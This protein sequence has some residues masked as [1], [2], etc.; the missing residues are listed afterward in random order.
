[1]PPPLV[2]GVKVSGG[3][4]GGPSHGLTYGHSC[5]RLPPQG[6]RPRSVPPLHRS[7]DPPAPSLA[8]HPKLSFVRAL[9]W[10][11]VAHLRVG[12]LSLPERDSSPRTR[13]TL[14][15]VFTAVPPVPS[16]LAPPK[17][18]RLQAWS[19]SPP[20]FSRRP[21]LAPQVLASFFQLPFLV[22]VNPHSWVV[23]AALY[24]CL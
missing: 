3:S 4:S 5:V 24:N 8:H 19:L 15:A 9:I 7:E 10:H 23:R 2:P 12:A 14:S 13:E 18:P 21:P 16:T 22:N 17:C 6:G 20:T 11:Y 1:M